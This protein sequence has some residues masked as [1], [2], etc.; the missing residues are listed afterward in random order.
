M[1]AIPFEVLVSDP[2]RHQRGSARSLTV[3]AVQLLPAI[4]AAAVLTACG[5]G[6][7][8]GG[9][10]TVSQAQLPATTSFSGTVRAKGVPLA[11]ATV[12]AFNTNTNST[13]ATTTTD[14]NGNYAFS[15]MGTACTDSCTQNFQFWAV[16]AGY[17]FYPVPAGNP[18]ASRASYQWD[19]A[20]SDWYVASGAAVTR[21]GYNGQFTNSGGGAGLIFTAYN[22]NSVPGAS[23]TGADFAGYDGSNPPV[24]LAASGQSV[25]YAAGD[26]ASKHSGVPWPTVRYLDNH[27]GT[28]TDALTGL[29]WL[30]D[31]SCLAPRIWTDAITAVNQL[32][33]G[34]CGLADSSAAGDWRMPNV[35]ELESIVDES[36]TSPALSSGSPFVNVN[37]TYWTSTSYYGGLTGS[38]AAWVIRMSDGRY[39]NDGATN[40]KTSSALGVWAVKGKANGVVQLQATGLYVP[41]AKGDDGNVGA[42]VPLTFPRMHDNADGTVTDTVTGLIWLKRADCINLTWSGALAAVNALAG[43]QCGLTDGSTAGSWRMPNRKELESLADRAQNNQADFFDTSWTS[44]NSTIASMGAVFT[45]FVQLQYYWTSTTDASDTTMAWTVFS[46]DYGVYDTLKANTGYTLAVR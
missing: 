9:A 27:D 28:V 25:S 34:S 37:G 35:W 18:A 22:F 32:A 39:I 46:C 13:F 11:A 12:I 42:G 16:K 26:D 4:A 41:Y 1:S 14:A 19:S 2:V 3:R 36:A 29:I 17:A 45:N 30:K 38:P 7:G 31:A 20:A 43:G 6:G 10:S 23:V 21:E 40:V 8:S 15:G 33:S 24:R 5:G 44:A